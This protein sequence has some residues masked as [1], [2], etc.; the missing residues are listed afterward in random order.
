[1]ESPARIGI[2]AH[3]RD[4]TARLSPSPKFSILIFFARNL[5][6]PCVLSVGSKLSVSL[7][8]SL[9]LSRALQRLA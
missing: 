3:S 8:L 6:L 4:E 9:S 5:Q 2:T 7:S 1:M